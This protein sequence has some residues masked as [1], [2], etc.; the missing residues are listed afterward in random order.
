MLAIVKVLKEYHNF[1]LGTRIAIFTDHKNLLS[2]T[3][4]NNSVFRW[5]QKIEEFSP[6]LQYV[7][8]RDNVE[9][10]VLIRLPMDAEAH[11]VMLNHPPMDPSDP[12]LN[13][14]P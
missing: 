1:L 6:I 13:K 3:T 11:E 5:K 8:G 4:V 9:T 7:K 14:N 10:D 12:L 2:N